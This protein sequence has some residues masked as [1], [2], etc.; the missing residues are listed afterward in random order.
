MDFNLNRNYNLYKFRY[1]L[2][3]FKN[4]KRTELLLFKEPKINYEKEP[5]FL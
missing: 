3:I 5:D 2:K 1:N 4:P